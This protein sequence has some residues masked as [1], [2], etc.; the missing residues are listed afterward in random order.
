MG[1]FR[2][3]VEQDTRTPEDV[4]NAHDKW[5][6]KGYGDGRHSEESAGWGL[7]AP[8]IRSFLGSGGLHKSKFKEFV[9]T[10]Q[11]KLASYPKNE[12]GVKITFSAHGRTHAHD[13]SVTIVVPEEDASNVFKTIS[14]YGRKLSRQLNPKWYQDMGDH[15]DELEYQKE[16]RKGSFDDYDPY[17][18]TPKPKASPEDISARAYKG[19]LG[20]SMGIPMPTK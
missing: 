18:P 13:M 6:A 7:N 20:S 8:Q 16:F 11:K 12:E 15:Y 14:D 2:N 10:M 5:K 9:E 4:K 19:P 3:F 1:E 17:V